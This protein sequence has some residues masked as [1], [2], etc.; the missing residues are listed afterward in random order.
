MD[1]NTK[2]KTIFS[3]HGLIEYSRLYGRDD[4]D[5]TLPLSMTFT[6]HHVLLLF[7]ER[8]TAV[9]LVTPAD[10]NTSQVTDEDY[11]SEVNGLIFLLLFVA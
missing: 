3:S 5:F 2:E 6:R 1:I 4:D 11:C 7:P 9:S 8:V 10:R